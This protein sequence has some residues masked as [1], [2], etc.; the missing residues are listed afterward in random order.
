ME[1]HKQ[2]VAMLLFS[3]YSL[4]PS[5]SMDTKWHNTDGSFPYST[6]TRM[7]AVRWE[8]T[9]AAGSMRVWDRNGGSRDIYTEETHASK[10]KDSPHGFSAVGSS[11]GNQILH[12]KNK[13]KT[14]VTMRN[15]LVQIRLKDTNL[16]ITF[17]HPDSFQ[18]TPPPHP[19]YTLPSLEWHLVHRNCVL[20]R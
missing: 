6:N 15:N 8:V 12:N 4:Y 13:M 7:C 1:A 9:A 14:V 19:T 17:G 3:F 5:I 16:D 10:L 2:R 20:M 11:M 18:G